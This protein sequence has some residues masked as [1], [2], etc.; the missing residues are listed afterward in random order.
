MDEGSCFYLKIECEVVQWRLFVCFNARFGDGPGDE[1]PL[2]SNGDYTRKFGYLKFSNFNNKTTNKDNNN[3]P[4]ENLLNSVLY[5]P[6]EVF[7]V[8]GYPKVRQHAFWVPVNPQY[9]E[10]TKKLEDLKLRSCLNATTCLP[11]RAVVVR[12]KRGISANVFVD[13][14]AYREFLNSHFEGITPIDM[15]SAAVA[16]VCFQQKI[17][18][19]ALRGLSD[20]AGGGSSLSNEAATFATLA[21]QNSVQ[22]LIRLIALLSS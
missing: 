21:A 2:E 10:V 13:N 22:V 8:F 7:P 18:F 11:R 19:I 15:E 16:I 20:L 3:M 5:P 12:V 1:L 17:P 6:K 14:R 4:I 9:F